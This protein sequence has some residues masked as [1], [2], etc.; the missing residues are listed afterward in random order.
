MSGNV[1][2][3]VAV[4][5]LVLLGLHDEPQSSALI[6]GSVSTHPVVIRR[7][8]GL[9]QRARLVV[10]RTGPGGGFRLARAPET[11]TLDEVFRAV[12]EAGAEPARHRPNPRCPVG[13]NVA[14]VLDDIGANAGRAFLGALAGQTVGDAIRKVRRRAGAALR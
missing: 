5:V 1:R 14:S 10:G 11:I 3:A 4:H 8:L 13:C 12:E 7:I 9:L 2:F 6:A